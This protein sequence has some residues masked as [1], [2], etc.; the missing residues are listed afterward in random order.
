MILEKRA[1]ITAKEAAEYIG[2]SYVKLLDMAKKNEVPHISAGTRVLFRKE[3]L[4]KWMDEKEAE[5]KNN[6]HNQYGVIRKLKS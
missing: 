2:I 1:T 5:Y 6:P 3:T 4:D